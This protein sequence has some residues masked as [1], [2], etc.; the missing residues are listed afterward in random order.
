M[1]EEEYTQVRMKAGLVPLS[2]WLKNLALQS[3]GTEAKSADLTS[4]AQARQTEKSESVRSG[5][6]ESP[7]SRHEGRVSHSPKGSAMSPNGA[8]VG[9]AANFEVSDEHPTAPTQSEEESDGESDD[10]RAVDLPE[11]PAV[12]SEAGREPARTRGRPKLARDGA[13][14]EV[15]GP[16]CKHGNAVGEYCGF[17]FGTVMPHMAKGVK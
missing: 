10:D 14:S 4:A 1:S 9:S 11:R 17:C 5:K 15:R 3:N 12:H 2:R 13:E 16:R 6:P 8:T 7:A